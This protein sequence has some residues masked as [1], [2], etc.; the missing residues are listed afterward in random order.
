MKRS[1]FSLLLFP[2]MLAMFGCDD[3]PGKSW[4]VNRTR[5]LGARISAEREPARAS[6]S[7]GETAF[8]DWLIPSPGLPPR[9]SWS[10]AACL[11]PEG[12]QADPRCEGALLTSGTGAAEPA[13]L[14]HM[15]M[16]LPASGAIPSAAQE[17]L[18]IAAFCPSESATLDAPSFT[19][20]C[21]GG[22]EP[23]LGS[24]SVRLSAAGPNLNPVI[25]DD[26][27]RLDDVVIPPATLGPD[28][29]ACTPSPDAPFM[30]AGGGERD[31]GFHFSGTEREAGEELEISHVVTTGELKRQRDGLAPDEPA[32]KDVTVAFTPPAVSEVGEGGRLVEMYFVLRD[33]RGGM[34][35]A[36]RTVCVRR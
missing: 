4:L 3:Q 21:A 33:G 5:I 23:L 31:L 30:A 6:V 2:V 22:A 24:V 1:T 29:A 7:P 13:V 15:I 17:V 11:P 34:G 26:A 35:F 18:V 14:P 20:T 9:L 16:A 8:I 32:P 12:T 19:A 36:R 10:F 28:G 25:A 27:I